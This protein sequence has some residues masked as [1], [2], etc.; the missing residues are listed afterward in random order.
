MSSNKEI[1]KKM[2]ISSNTKSKT[3][4]QPRLNNSNFNNSTIN[5][6]TKEDHEV[7]TANYNDFN[8]FIENNMSPDYYNMCGNK[9]SRKLSQVTGSYKDG[10]YGIVGDKENLNSNLPRLNENNNINNIN[11]EEFFNL[12][13]NININNE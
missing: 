13:N 10:N 5:K 6:N 4:T 12:Q 2:E 9:F 1:P 3:C 8:L 7:K 11:N